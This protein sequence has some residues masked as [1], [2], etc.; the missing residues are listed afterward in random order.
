MRHVKTPAIESQ[1][2]EAEHGFA[3]ALQRVR[4]AL[5]HLNDS[6]LEIAA[7]RQQTALYEGYTSAIYH[8]SA[9]PLLANHED[10]RAQVVKALEVELE[11]RCGKKEVGAE[12]NAERES[13]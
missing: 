13:S 9:S 11:S 2:R 1:L 10:V 12:A 7:A 4:M 8:I 5:S 3:A 6:E